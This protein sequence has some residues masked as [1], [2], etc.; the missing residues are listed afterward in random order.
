M[1]ASALV[2]PHRRAIG[3]VA[4]LTLAL[5]GWR[6]VT[7]TA[8]DRDARS[9]LPVGTALPG[10]VRALAQE[11][12]AA[13]P[14][15]VMYISESCPHCRVE[16]ARWD[17][18]DGAGALP[19]SLRRL[20]VIAP[21]AGQRSRLAAFPDVTLVDGDHRIAAALRIRVV[22]TAYW[23][24]TSGVIREVTRGESQPA[25]IIGRARTLAGGDQ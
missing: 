1:T 7:R 2:A 23:V 22:P 21:G 6:S 19:S 4:L 24:D 11:G 5:G 8:A 9:P 25:A 17:S 15:V 12:A 14:T 10:F 13:R 18:L 3:V 16:V 20:L